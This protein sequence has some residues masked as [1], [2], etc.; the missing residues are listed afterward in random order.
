MTKEHDALLQND[1]WELVPPDSSQKVVGCKWVYRIKY[2]P[3][4]SIE[5]YKARLV[6]KGFHQRP[7]IDY[8]ETFSPVIKPTTVRLMLSVSVNNGWS[9]R[10]LDINNAF[11][12]GHLSEDVYMSQPPGFIDK[13]YPSYVCKLKKSIYGLR[14]SPRVWYQ[15][16]H[17]F[18]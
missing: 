14:Q 17:N 7:G 8:S 10:Q 6:V 9:I 1:T 12:Q 18:Y 5:R 2:K 15:E 3:D 4:N 16:L 13:D 11:L